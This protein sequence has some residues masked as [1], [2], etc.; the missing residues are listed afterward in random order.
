[1][2]VVTLAFRKADVEVDL[3]GTGF[4]V[5]P[6]DRRTIKGV[7]LSSQKWGWLG[8]GTELVTLRCSIGRLGEEAV[9]QRDDADLVEAATADLRAATRAGADAALPRTASSAHIA[10]AIRRLTR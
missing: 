3:P 8:E 10:R 2:A 9:L 6:V 7:T 5:P 4:L 1:M